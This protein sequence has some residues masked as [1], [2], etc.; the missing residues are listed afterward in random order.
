[1]CFHSFRVSAL[2]VSAC[3]L[4]E[5]QWVQT[6][7]FPMFCRVVI[8]TSR[9]VIMIWGTVPFNEIEL[10]SLP[11]SGLRL[12]RLCPHPWRVSRTNARSLNNVSFSGHAVFYGLFSYPESLISLYP[13]VCLFVDLFE[14]LWVE[15]KACI[16]PLSDTPSPLGSFWCWVKCHHQTFLVLQTTRASYLAFWILHLHFMIDSCHY[17]CLIQEGFIFYYTSSL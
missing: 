13:G 5:L 2:P 11:I 7:F 10:W 1:M 4:V 12:A 15:P 6:T 14:A 8:V 9:R 16:L 17:V 3:F